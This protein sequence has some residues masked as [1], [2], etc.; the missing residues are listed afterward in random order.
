MPF[1]PLAEADNHRFHSVAGG[2]FFGYLFVECSL[3][4]V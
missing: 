1:D 4:D 3:Y 2:V